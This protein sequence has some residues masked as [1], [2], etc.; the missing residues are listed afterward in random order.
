MKFKL[1][2]L[3]DFDKESVKPESGVLYNVYSLPGYD[4]NR[5]PELLIGQ[6]IKSNKY[7][8]EPDTILMNKL[9]VGFKRV[10]LIKH[11]VPNSIASTE[12]VPL[13]VKNPDTVHLGY[14]YY[15]LTTHDVTETLKKAATGTSNSHQR[16]NA[17]LIANLEIDLPLF[18]EQRAIAEK[19]TAIDSKITLNRE[20]NDNLAA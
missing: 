11:P 12:F 14:I 9:N 19:L 18:D 16:I 15:F 6:D 8:V 2:D 13:S 1:G 7:A 5:Q 20:I 3:L 17:A 10:W 4:A